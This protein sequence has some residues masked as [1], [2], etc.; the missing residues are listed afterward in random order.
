MKL[1]NLAL[2][3]IVGSF[4][5]G[6]PVRAA[7]QTFYF[8]NLLSPSGPSFVDPDGGATWAQLSVS[9]LAENNISSS[10]ALSLK[11][12]NGTNG[13]ASFATLFGNAAFVS[14]SIFNL[15]SD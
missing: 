15:P 8:G 13:L 10:Y 6:T 9:T 14:E 12:G 4:A 2:A 5:A 1:H 3:V 11:L 7:T